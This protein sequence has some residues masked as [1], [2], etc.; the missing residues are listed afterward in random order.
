ML[1]VKCLIMAYKTVDTNN[2]FEIEWKEYVVQ[3][4]GSLTDFF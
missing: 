4:E 1:E 3:S 2:L